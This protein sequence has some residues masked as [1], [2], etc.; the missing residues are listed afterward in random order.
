MIQLKTMAALLCVSA[1][2]V[3]GINMPKGHAAEHTVVYVAVN[4]NDSA[5]GTLDAPLATLSA[6]KAR[7]RDVLKSGGSAEVVFREGEYP[8]LSTCNFTAED[9]G[10]ADNPV[11]YRAMENERVVFKGSKSFAS[12]EM[13]PV[14]DEAMLARIQE[15]VR[16]RIVVY[17]ISKAGFTQN[18]IKQNQNI[19]AG[20][21][22][23][24]GAEA[25]MLYVDGKEQTIA[26]WPNGDGVYAHWDAAEDG[27]T[28]H[29]TES[30]PCRWTAAKD[31][32][33]GG[34]Q[35]YDFRYSRVSGVS[36]DPEKRTLTAY[37]QNNNFQF[38]SYQSR[39]WKAFNLIEELDLPGEFYIDRDQMKLYFYP[40]QGMNNAKLELS[41][42]G[43]NMIDITNSQNITFRG[44][45]FSRTRG[46]AVVLTDVSNIDF[47]GCTFSDISQ[48]GIYAKGS[49][50]AVTDA[51][52]WQFQQIDGSYGCDIRQCRFENIGGSAIDIS[53]GNVD[54]LKKSNNVI[55]DNIFYR[56]SQINKNNNAIALRGCGN[57][58]THNNISRCAFQ[59][60]YYIGND[61]T[62]MY[63]EIY[64][65]IQET[66][67]CGAIYCGRNVLHQ[68]TVIAYNYLHDLFSTEV[69]P[70]GHQT[71]I[72]WDD[73]HCGN[74][75]YNNIIKNVRKN[76]YTNGIDNTFRDNVSINLTA[77]SMDIKNGGAATNNNAGG[78]SFGSVIA[79]EK[80]YFSHYK[81]L[82]K[83]I[84]SKDSRDP[85]LA[86]FNT[87]SGNLDV[88]SPEQII[89]TYTMQYGK[90]VNNVNLEQCNDFVNPE[91]QDYRL[92][93]GSETAKRLPGLLTD[94]FDIEQIGMQE[95][96]VQNGEFKK[97]YP[98][99]GARAVA[100][101]GMEFKWENA[102]GASKY[103]LV[104]A[105]DSE[106]KNIVYDEIADYNIQSVDGLEKNKT[107]YW[108]VYAISHSRE[109]GGN[110]ESTD[111]VY[112]FKTAIY[113][114]LDTD[115]FQKTV[116][117]ISEKTKT[118]VESE[119][120][121]EY[122]VG[123]KAALEALIDRSYVVA[124][125]RLGMFTQK[126]FDALA[127]RIAGF[128]SKQGMVN[129]GA[130]D[131][132][133]YIEDQNIWSGDME[134]SDK[135]VTL[136]GDSSR[137]TGTS[138]AGVKNLERMT[139]SVLYCFDAQMKIEKN[140]I[141]IGLNKFIDAPQ[142]QPANTGY[143]LVIK[144]DCIELQYSTGTA[145]G[146]LTTA[147]YAV[148]SEKHSFE[149]GFVNI[150]VGNAIVLN[151][152]GK[153]IIE[154]NDVVD[155]KVNS[156][157]NL[158]LL[159]YN[160]TENSVTLTRSEK[161]MTGESFDKMVT[162]SLYKSAKPLIDSIDSGYNEREDFV[163]FKSG[164]KKVLTENK[165]V[166]ISDSP[167]TLIDNEFYVPAA[168]LG[169]MLGI[170]V[171]LSGDECRI[172]AGEKTAAVKC[173]DNMVSVEAVLKAIGR[174][175]VR[176]DTTQLLVVGNI[177]TM[178]NIRTLSGLS[179][180][181]SRLDSLDDHIDVNY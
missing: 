50:N 89:G 32:W 9:S 81:N 149:F 158:S 159:V 45:T 16:D 59:G 12:T 1:L 80:L 155:T 83:I 10:S 40:P 15:K 69:L 117:E 144:P 150:G 41:V 57:V 82:E 14:E 90:V 152:D 66:D 143:C 52:Y 137:S 173:R 94:S 13:K 84:M 122:P 54:T 133:K 97:I 119:E 19:G 60:V 47:I 164:S 124:N 169:D 103:R 76:I 131:F 114:K 25:N 58:F 108:T 49:K 72:Y 181:M 180:L 73:A 35:D 112:S 75:A 23:L 92:K 8:I 64:D 134:F 121:G 17:D 136:R 128:F 161:I 26:Q 147:D 51:A 43:D 168:R 135:A 96:A 179:E 78:S 177:V 91:K 38:I 98:Q 141:V 70:F 21:G 68:G 110:W 100:V 55:D 146:I 65:V 22:K 156:L 163:I 67:D 85:K 102:F 105:T 79:D 74:T 120:P 151:I 53:G 106:M 62:I 127:E 2:A 3:F 140:F 174:G 107:Y 88:N 104:I 130:I 87:M 48:M 33:I 56:C 95:N 138:M 7:V 29:F 170:E 36:V 20:T 44:I 28:I 113:E 160:N 77:A 31:W 171:Q 11:I 5:A 115:Y 109:L 116:S 125:S 139:G 111:G 148:G 175:Y 6:A 178:N 157:C 166:D 165:A 99:N 34:Y 61:H 27:R 126:G 86:R 93:S 37:N 101:A 154:Y 71:A 30:A 63:N 145:H 4:G 132:G 129:T 172:T 42:I 39:R 118:I 162:D 24:R 18:E 46:D 142:F 167:C 176:D 153:N 123:T